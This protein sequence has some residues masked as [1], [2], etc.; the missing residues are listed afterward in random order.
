MREW[1]LDRWPEETQ[2]NL[3]QELSRLKVELR[4]ERE[5]MGRQHEAG[6]ATGTEER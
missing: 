6:R 4:L 2:I 1:A 3:V 5:P